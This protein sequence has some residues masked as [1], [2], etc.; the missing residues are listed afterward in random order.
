[1]DKKKYI[2]TIVFIICIII[3]ITNIFKK[4]NTEIVENEL[5]NIQEQ[6]NEISNLKNQTGAQADN[7]LYM[8][9]EEY[10]GRKALV[11]KPNIQY[12][13]IM[14]GI[15]K[16]AKPEISEISNYIDTFPTKKGI[17][18]SKKSREGFLS[19]LKN[20]TNSEYYI[21]EEGYLKLNTLNNEYDKIINEIINS[22][23]CISIDLGGMLY[24]I[25]DMT[26]EVLEYPFED[27]DPYQPYEKYGYE[28]NSIY[29]VTTNKKNKLDE[30]EIIK[31]LINN[32][33]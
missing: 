7:E 23:K 12:N 22:N 1:M 26:G 32:L 11:I 33:K 17:W 31:E 20:I 6:N 5:K 15:I 4:T 25:D 18:I 19:L 27:M 14:T 10:D 30:S 24:I 2:I 3:L 16:E 13:I 8:I 29:I 28:N 21:D 9:G